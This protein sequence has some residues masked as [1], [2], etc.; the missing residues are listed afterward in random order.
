MVETEGHSLLCVN[1]LD[2]GV[3]YITFLIPYQPSHAALWYKTYIDQ[4]SWSSMCKTY[5][6]WLCSNSISE[7]INVLAMKSRSLETA[8]AWIK[9]HFQWRTY[10][11]LQEYSGSENQ[12]TVC[13]S[14]SAIAV[15]F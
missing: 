14:F 4:S 2:C 9:N 11:L 6:Y 1:T 13:G 15:G 10:F 8:K 3:G 5:Q 12:P 7:R